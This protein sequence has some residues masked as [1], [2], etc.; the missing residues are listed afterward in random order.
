MNRWVK[1]LLMALLFSIATVG[2]ARCSESSLTLGVF[3]RRNAQITYDSFTP[4]AEYLSVELGRQVTLDVSNDFASFWRKMANGKFDLIHCNQYHYLAAHRDFNFEVL[5]TNEEFGKTT[6]GGSIIVRKDS[7]LNTAADLKGKR[8]IFGGGDTAML[9][10]IVATHLLR[11]AGLKTGDYEEV[12]AINPP[13]AVLA[14]YYQQTDASGAGDN[15]IQMETV[16]GR[17]D[18]TELKYLLR[19]PQLP[20]LPWAISTSLAPEIRFKIRTTLTT[21]DQSKL[22]QDALHAAFL[23]RINPATDQDFNPFRVLVQEIK[24]EQY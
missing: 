17:I 23:D 16:K 22:G 10:Y 14:T 8:I 6:I 18:I 24:G 15:S 19:S 2:S 9:S 1:V 12:F 7:G 11:Q 13:N 20:Q 3:P 4:L 5:G 21:M